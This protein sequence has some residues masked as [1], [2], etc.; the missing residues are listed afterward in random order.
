MSRYD[1]PLNFNAIA[2][3]I[4]VMVF[5]LVIIHNILLVNIPNYKYFH[6]GYQKWKRGI[7]W[8]VLQALDIN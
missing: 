1:W 4:S 2:T 5:L 8:I 6:F 7:I 3:L